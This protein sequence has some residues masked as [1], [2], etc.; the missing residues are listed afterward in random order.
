LDFVVQGV[1][2]PDATTTD[3]RVFV[4][5]VNYEYRGAMF[6]ATIHFDWQQG[7]LQVATQGQR[8]GIPMQQILGSLLAK[9]NGGAHVAQTH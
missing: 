9:I 6:D 1:N 7:E 5:V 8:M 3:G 2:V 4:A